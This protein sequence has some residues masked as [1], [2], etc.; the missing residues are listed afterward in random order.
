MDPQLNGHSVSNES[1]GGE[2]SSES[3]IPLF[4][5][6]VSDTYMTDNIIDENGNERRDSKGKVGRTGRF[7]CM[8]CGQTFGRVEHL[9]R[10]GKIHTQEGWL[11]CAIEGCEKGFY[12]M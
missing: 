6:H 11:R 12:R 10:H 1:V 3:S 7:K 9:T 2:R 4:L 8:V 5:M